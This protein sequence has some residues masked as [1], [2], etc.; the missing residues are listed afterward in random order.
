[1]EAVARHDF[2]ATADDELSFNR[3]DVLKILKIDNELRWYRAER[4]GEEGLVPSNYIE[5]KDHRWYRGSISRN[6][7]ENL[8]LK[9]LPSNGRYL[10]DDG[11]FLIRDSQTTPGELS[12]SV[13]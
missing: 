12:V 7:T 6:D 2:H 4:N 13:K 8:L 1:M 10:Y 9:R 5:M 3:S 11:M